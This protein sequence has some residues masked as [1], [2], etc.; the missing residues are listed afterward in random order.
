MLLCCA[1]GCCP[2]GNY[3]CCPGGEFC[4]GTVAQCPDCADGGRWCRDD[5][6]TEDAKCCSGDTAVCCGYGDAQCVADAA[7]CEEP[8]CADGDFCNG[9]DGRCC[10]KDAPQCCGGNTCAAADATCCDAGNVCPK[11]ENCCMNG[12]KA[13]YVDNEDEC[14]DPTCPN[15]ADYC[16]NDESLTTDCC[17]LTAPQCCGKAKCVAADA[18]C[19]TDVDGA[20]CPAGQTC[21]EDGSGGCYETADTECTPPKK[22]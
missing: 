12:S 14:P 3:I 17:G 6:G 15:T 2:D 22:H 21:C 16:P 11:G 7:D 20:S 8:T 5:N 4:A 13:C 18:T 1:A 9:A 19:C 10:D